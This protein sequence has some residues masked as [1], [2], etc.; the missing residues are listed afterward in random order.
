[1]SLC[2]EGAAVFGS[3]RSAQPLLIKRFKNIS[4]FI[5]TLTESHIKPSG[6]EIT[7]QP[8]ATLLYDQNCMTLL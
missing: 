3:H 2:K 4:H 1:M 7:R 6:L 8:T 5:N